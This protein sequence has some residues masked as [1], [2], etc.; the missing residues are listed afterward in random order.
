MID[1]HI[2]SKIARKI[3]DIVNTLTRR[4]RFLQIIE[5]LYKVKSKETLEECLVN[6]ET[7]SCSCHIQQV[8]RI[9]CGHAFTVII[10]GLKEDLQIYIEQFYTL[11][12]FRNMYAS[13]IIHSHNMDSFNEPLI[14]NNFNFIS[15]GSDSDG[16]S[17]G[18]NSLSSLET[19]SNYLLP[20]NSLC[21]SGRLKKKRIQITE[22]PQHIQKCTQCREV[23]HSKKTC[24]ENI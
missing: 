11:K 24:R 17:S 13:I 3:Q 7:H 5:H 8:T 14:F 18:S 1:R 23:G 15:H 19:I 21:P 12:A 10:G 4:Y 9:S 16:D 6:L 22:V 20:P 2:V